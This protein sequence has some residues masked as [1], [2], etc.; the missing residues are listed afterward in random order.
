MEEPE[1]FKFC[2]QSSGSL[3]Q[4]TTEEGSE[5]W[6]KS[7]VPVTLLLARHSHR[8]CRLTDHLGAFIPHR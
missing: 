7:S 4:L 2:I 8:W 6:L 1:L 3:T 5:R